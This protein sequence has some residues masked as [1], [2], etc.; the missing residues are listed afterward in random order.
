M[1]RRLTSLA[2]TVLAGGAT[3]LS[4]TPANAAS[5]LTSYQGDDYSV[6]GFSSNGDYVYICDRERDG[7]GVHADYVILGSSTNQQVRNESGSGTC[8]RSGFYPEG[9]YRHRAVEEI[10]FQEDPKGPW[11][12]PYGA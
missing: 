1:R 11:Q 6:N 7:H 4:A 9:I 3:I 12:Y 8:A 10:P 5:S 2:V